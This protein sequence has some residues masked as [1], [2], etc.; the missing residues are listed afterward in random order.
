[1]FFG[2]ISFFLFMFIIYINIELN[3][4]PIIYSDVL[5]K[6]NEKSAILE[7]TNK[8][9]N[10]RI[11]SSIRKKSL[12]QKNIFIFCNLKE[13]RKEIFIIKMNS[14]KYKDCYQIFYDINYDEHLNQINKRYYILDK[15]YKI[16]DE[17][18][19]NNKIIY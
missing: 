5:I 18:E 14:F 4:S 16:I 15:F 9:F 8:L 3:R 17:V 6:E 19:I 13:L 7:K 1:M 11:D 10:D 2:V 12:Y